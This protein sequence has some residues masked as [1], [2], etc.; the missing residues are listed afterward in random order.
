MDFIP[1]NTPVFGK[2]EEAYLMECIRSGWISSEGPFVKRFEESLG[3]RTNRE[4]GVAVSSGSAALDIAIEALDIGPGDEVIV[5]SFTIISCISQILRK[6]AK[7]VFVD[8]SIETW[9]MSANEVRDRITEKTK[10]IIV[11]HIYGLPADIDQI[12]EIA[13]EWKIPVIED[14]AEA[15]GLTYKGRPCGSHGDI[16]ILSFY[17]NK[18]VTTGEGGMV[19]TNSRLIADKCNGLRNLCFS[20]DP[21]ERFIH[22]ELGWNYRMSNLQAAVGLAQLERLDSTMS[23]KRQ[24]GSRYNEI[25]RDVEGLQLPV[26]S[27]EYAVNCYWVFG[28]LAMGGSEVKKRIMAYLKDK[29]IGLRPF[30]YPLHRQPVLRSYGVE[31]ESY[32][33][34][35]SDKLYDSGFYLPSGL[36]LKDDEI[37]YVGETLKWA[38]KEYC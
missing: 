13:D 29:N 33:C 21:A 2:T 24:I 4:Y 36:G 6:G 32:D 25:L 9:N 8:S 35:N 1:V 38:A 17:P 26:V 15:L 18:H 12:L 31:P 14:A 23:R 10:A 20:P 11:V 28:V 22:R 27:T 7:P 30:F 16:S 34:P 19:L 5:P 37:T 3:K